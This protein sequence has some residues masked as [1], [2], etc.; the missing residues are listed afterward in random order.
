[1]KRAKCR[2]CSRPEARAPSEGR[3]LGGFCGL[4]ENAWAQWWLAARPEAFAEFAT[5]RVRPVEETLTEA[6]APPT[7]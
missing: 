3:R 6:E 4:H 2:Y 5:K 1:M 7:S